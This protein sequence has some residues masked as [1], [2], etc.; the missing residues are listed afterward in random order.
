VLEFAFG[1]F[2][3]LKTTSFTLSGRSESSNLQVIER[4]SGYIG[5]YLSSLK[6]LFYFASVKRPT[7]L[8]RPPPTRPL[9]AGGVVGFTAS[10]S[11]SSSTGDW[12]EDCLREEP[13]VE[14]RG[15][16]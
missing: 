10:A 4:S 2:K 5:I 12:R 16:G 6:R 1:E 14:V 15:A 8:R 9:R 7:L 13:S 3:V 11:A